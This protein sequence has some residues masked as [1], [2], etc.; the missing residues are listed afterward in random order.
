MQRPADRKDPSREIR[1]VGASAMGGGSTIHHLGRT[2]IV[3]RYSRV[4]A[5]GAFARRVVLRRRFAAGR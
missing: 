3:V 1:Q 5:D 2:W 4:L